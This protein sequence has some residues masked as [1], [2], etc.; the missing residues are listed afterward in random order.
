VRK[1]KLAERVG[2]TVRERRRALGLSRAEVGRAIGVADVEV[3]RIER[4]ERFPRELEALAGALAWEVRDL[5]TPVH[6]KRTAPVERVIAFLE[7]ATLR[8]P[9][10]PSRAMRVLRAIDERPKR[11]R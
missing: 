4:G 3:G 11:G 9:S 10:F 8:D 7:G 6:R 1:R 2:E 5:F